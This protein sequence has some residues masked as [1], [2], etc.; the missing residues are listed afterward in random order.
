MIGRPAAVRPV[1][2]ANGRNPLSIGC[3]CHR[4]IGTGGPVTG[5]AAKRR[6]WC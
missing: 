4:V 2:T 5:F 6:L 1:G 3:P